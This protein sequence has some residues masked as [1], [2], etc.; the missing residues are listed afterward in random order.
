MACDTLCS[1]CSKL[2]YVF[3]QGVT[4]SLTQDSYHACFCN[5]WL[6]GTLRPGHKIADCCCSLWAGRNRQ[7]TVNLSGTRLMCT[8]SRHAVVPA[9]DIFKSG[10]TT[11]TRPGVI[12]VTLTSENNIQKACLI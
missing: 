2:T 1:H 11:A 12:Q 6:C 4:R 3:H 8:P 10:V 5:S 7:W 9:V